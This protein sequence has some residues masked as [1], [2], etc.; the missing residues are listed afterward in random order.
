MRGLCVLCVLSRRSGGGLVGRRRSAI[1]STTAA[2][3]PAP[4]AP[5]AAA[6]AFTLAASATP[7][8]AVVSRAAFGS[9]RRSRT[10]RTGATHGTGSRSSSGRVGSSGSSGGG[11]RGGWTRICTSMSSCS[12][13]RRRRIGSGCGCRSFLTCR[14]RLFLFGLDRPRSHA[15]LFRQ[16]CRKLLS[17]QLRQ[18]GQRGGMHSAGDVHAVPRSAWPAAGCRLHL[19]QLTP[20]QRRAHIPVA[21]QLLLL[22]DLQQRQGRGYRSSGRGRSRRGRALALLALVWC[23]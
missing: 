23:G 9:V 2:P 21:A 12:S 3:A 20:R 18:G 5:A 16:L 14:R 19:F 6:T 10:G 1:R 4:S 15:L 22:L 17:L 7:A 11:A 8:L 13:D